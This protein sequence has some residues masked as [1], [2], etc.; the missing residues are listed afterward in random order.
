MNL[1]FHA[2][3]H[4]TG[5]TTFQSLL[6]SL[7]DELRARDI[8]VPV[9]G[10][11][12]NMGPSVVYPA[13][14]GDWSGYDFVLD[15]A[16]AALT[17]AGILLFSAEDLENCLRDTEFGRQFM[18]RARAKGATSIH[19]VFVQRNE[20]EYFESLYGELSR[21]R[22]VLQY[23]LMADEILEHGFFSCATS[24]FRWFFE[25]R[26]ESALQ[27]FRDRVCAQTS[28]LTFSEFTQDGVGSAVFG[29]FGREDDYRGLCSRVS[30]EPQNVRLA[31]DEVERNYAA[32]FLRLG[33]PGLGD[34]GQAL[35]TD[36]LVARRL[37]MRARCRPAIRRRFESEFGCVPSTPRGG[38]A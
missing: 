10:G 18:L 2:G 31:D 9:V 19:W 3:H 36:A 12:A 32:T 11:T 4:K 37:E 6:A 28:R 33:E 8:H 7:R 38:S 17:P 16:R 34:A 23:D 26:Y 30:I 27:R 35:R 1:V 20:F 15:E 5:T 21:H 24:H 22:Q 14:R 13:Q 25:F 29:L